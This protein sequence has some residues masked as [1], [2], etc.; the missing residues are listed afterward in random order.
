M[1]SHQVVRAAVLLL[2]SGASIQIL[3]QAGES[4]PSSA[5]DHSPDSL[6][7]VLRPVV[8]A[9][10]VG[11]KKNPPKNTGGQTKPAQTFV[12]LTSSQKLAYGARRAFLDPFA[13]LGPAVNAFFVERQDVKAPGKT[14]EDKFADGLT[15]YARTFATSSTT[16]ML[17]SGIY[18]VL[19]KQDPRYHFSGKHGFM[20]RA[21]Y[22]ASR[23]VVTRGDNGE[24][25]P[26]YSRFAGT[27]TSVALANVYERDLVKARN[28]R[29]Q[30]VEF[31][32]R[33]GIEPT[34]KNL[35]ISMAANAAGNI[36]FHEF[37]VVGKLIKILHKP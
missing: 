6:G 28:L 5:A 13:Y 9:A 23:T 17:S 24:L 1:I 25:Q 16:T 8:S 32:R 36:V 33:V 2:L 4:R 18:P 10:T 3:A 11:Q 34:F 14:F 21:L 31:R 37:D 22:A 19:F 15:H 12:P 7:E 27:I 26:N 20:S 29:G 30:A 35:G